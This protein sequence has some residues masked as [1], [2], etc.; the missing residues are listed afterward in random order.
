MPLYVCHQYHDPRTHSSPFRSQLRRPDFC[1]PLRTAMLQGQTSPT[2]VVP[3]TPNVPPPLTLQRISCNAP[4][5]HYEDQSTSRNIPQQV[6]KL[7]YGPTP[8]TLP[9]RSAAPRRP[10][11]ACGARKGS[12]SCEKCDKEFA[13]RQSLSRHR[14]EKHGPELCI[15][16]GA[17]KWGRRYLLKAHLI[18]RHPELNTDLAL[19]EAVGARHGATVAKAPDTPTGSNF[20]D[21]KSPTRS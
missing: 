15:Y 12:Y 13:Q 4:M 5:T 6:R 8:G 16:C 19:D 9:R 11:N 17:F 7:G 3:I 18:K 10:S 2:R 20:R 14:W 1:Y 21:R